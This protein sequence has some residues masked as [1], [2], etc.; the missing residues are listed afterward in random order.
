MQQQKVHGLLGGRKKGQ[1]NKPLT[2][3]CTHDWKGLVNRLNNTHPS[4]CNYG[5][6]YTTM[7]LSHAATTPLSISVNVWTHRQTQAVMHT[8]ME[9][10]TEEGRLAANRYIWQHLLF[11]NLLKE[12][13]TSK[14]NAVN[15]QAWLF[16]LW[17]RNKTAVSWSN[18]KT[19]QQR[20]VKGDFNHRLCWL[21]IESY[22]YRQQQWDSEHS[23]FLFI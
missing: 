10:D 18:A 3:N 1:K 20:K 12:M 9:W 23:V 13:Y 11:C 5:F 19:Q 22:I 6:H 14:Q 4:P 15:P 21:P 8:C 7:L 2:E 16:S 17:E